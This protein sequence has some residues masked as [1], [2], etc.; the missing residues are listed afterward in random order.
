MRYMT[1][2]LLS[3]CLLLL[4]TACSGGHGTTVVLREDIGGTARFHSRTEALPGSARFECIASASGTCHYAV[5]GGACGQLAHAFAA[6][7]IACD[8]DAAPAARFD[9]AVGERRDIDGLPLDFRHCVRERP[10]AITAAC[11]EPGTDVMAA[12]ANDADPTG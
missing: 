8:A 9:L 5:F 3:L 7:V 6:E 11:L 4:A 2:T 10:G 1:T 12:R